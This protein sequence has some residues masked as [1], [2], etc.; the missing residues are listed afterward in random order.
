[1]ETRRYLPEAI[2][3]VAAAFVSVLGGFD[4]LL[5]ALLVCVILDYLSG[6]IAA[7]VTRTLSSSTGFNGILKKLAVF[8]V[9]ALA[10]TAD[11]VFGSGGA[12]RGAMIG[13]F[14]ANEGL[15]VLENAERIGLPI[16][17]KLIKLLNGLREESDEGDEDK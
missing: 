13:F 5:R 4:A 16:P 15:S 3:S 11:G 6:V 1:M 14:I 12:V 10:S 17:K 8:M 9:I 7:C 2:L